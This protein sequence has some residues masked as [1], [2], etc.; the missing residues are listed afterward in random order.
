VTASAESSGYPRHRCDAD[1]RTVEA[2]HQLQLGRTLVPEALQSSRA[3][4]VAAPL[5]HVP[6]GV[7]APNDDREECKLAGRIKGDLVAKLVDLLHIPFRLE[8][9][10]G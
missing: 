10:S 1:Q 4:F 3:D 5:I 6:W 9:A 8:R 7:L 2:K